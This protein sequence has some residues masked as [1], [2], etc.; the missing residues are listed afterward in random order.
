MS[1]LYFNYYG[2]QLITVQATDINF[3]NYLQG[4]PLENNIYT[5]PGSNI[6]GG[7]GLFSSHTY[8]K[9]YVYLKK[10]KEY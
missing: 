1:W 7:Y 8:E 3:Y 4:D 2:L 6:E 9:F 5:L 10:G